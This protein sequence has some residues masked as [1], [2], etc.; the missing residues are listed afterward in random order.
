M[1]FDNSSNATLRG[2]PASAAVLSVAGITKRYTVFQQPLQ[3]LLSYFAPGHRARCDTFTA[4]KEINFQ[5]H[6]GETLG[7][8][9]K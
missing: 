9:P 7:L 6:R 2:G 8:L 1:S 3:R 4:L 5:L